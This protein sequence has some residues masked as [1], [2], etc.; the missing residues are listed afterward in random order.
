MTQLLLTTKNYIDDVLS[1][2]GVR[3]RLDDDETGAIT[4]EDLDRIDRFIE[5]SSLEVG[6]ILRHR[7]TDV[8]YQGSNPPDNTPAAVQYM[9]A[10]IAA[11]KIFGRRGLPAYDELVRQFE[12]VQEWLADIKA[13]RLSLVNVAQYP[14][15]NFEPFVSN[16]TIDQRHRHAKARVVRATS[17]GGESDRRRHLERTFFTLFE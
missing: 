14:T 5:Q 12:M 8:E 10:I 15:S 11:R 16:F 3:H 1:E 17:K 6:M 7:Y 4:T 9:V 13:G 2:E